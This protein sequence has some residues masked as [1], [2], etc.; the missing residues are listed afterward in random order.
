VPEL[1]AISACLLGVRCRYDGGHNEHP[2][3]LA[4]CASGCLVPLCPEQLGGLSTPRSPAEIENG[5]GFAVLA[6]RARV[7]DANG[8][9]VTPAFLKGAQETANICRRL[10]IRTVLLKARSPS[11]GVGEIY[12]R[13]V[14]VRGEGVTAALLA[15]M[16]IET[17]RHS[18]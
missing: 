13:S 7:I 6:G 4:R 11:C 5:D 3:A 2:A 16:G 1:L 15:Q 14:P 8:V 9:D 18:D 10:D 17:L 12:R